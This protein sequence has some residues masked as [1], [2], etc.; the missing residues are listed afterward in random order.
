M[1]LVQIP[2][3]FID[4]LTPAE[5][6]SQINFLVIGTFNPG[7]PSLDIASLAVNLQEK[8]LKNQS[9]LNFYDRPN[10]RFW[11]VIDRIFFNNEYSGVSNDFKRLEGL[12]YYKGFN[13]PISVNKTQSEF[14]IK[15]GIFITDIVSKIAVDTDDLNKIYDGYSDSFFDNSVCEWNTNN[16]ISLINQYNPKRVLFTFSKSKAIPEI[17]KNVDCILAGNETR[18]FF[19]SSPSG[20][21]KNSYLKLIDDWSV[22][23]NS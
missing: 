14:C 2:H 1:A 22:H 3:K 16:I 7:I 23:F 18:A 6:I 10:N 9:G 19:L 20:N 8:I 15:N 4:K 21:A 13:D 11:G 17:S 12:K 5:E